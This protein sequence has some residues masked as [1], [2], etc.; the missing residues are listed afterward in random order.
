[1]EVM[2]L[3]LK[4]QKLEE[5]IASQVV[6]TPSEVDRY[7]RDA[8]TKMYFKAASFKPSDFV[9][10]QKALKAFFEKNKEQYRC[11]KVAVFPLGKDAKAAEKQ[12]YEF[13]REVKQSEAN[14]VQVAKKRNIKVLPEQWLT[15]APESIKDFAQFQ[16]AAAIFAADA[17]KP[18]TKVIRSADNNL[19]VGCLVGKSDKDKFAA[20]KAQ[21]ERQWRLEEARKKAELE[22]KRLNGI[23]DRALREKAFLELKK[24]KA[25]ITD[26][27]EKGGGALRDGETFA[28]GGRVYLLQKREIPTA[29]APEKDRAEYGEKCRRRKAE[30][31]RD[32]FRE[33]LGANC[34]FLLDQE[35]RR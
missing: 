19:Y 21:L 9:P 26:K 32:A 23:A 4:L 6:V 29:G 16:L 14:F 25:T 34:K 18:V 1:M 24:A 30:V 28:V 27:V 31:L 12:I 35:G 33:E 22:S 13:L 3:E 20:I 5:Y 8:N 10:T 7:Y 17:R 11:V 2:R 15:M